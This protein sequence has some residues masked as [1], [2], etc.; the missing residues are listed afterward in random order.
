LRQRSAQMLDSG[1]VPTP[2]APIKRPYRP[3]ARLLRKMARITPPFPWAIC[4]ME[5]LASRCSLHLKSGWCATEI[6][7]C[8]FAGRH[9]PVHA[10]VHRV[11]VVSVSACREGVKFLILG[12]GC[13]QIHTDNCIV[14]NPCALVSICG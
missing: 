3:H 1:N 14:L 5:A 6:R 12:H 4:P 8:E 2:P 9:C 7:A 11:P 10:R 13:I